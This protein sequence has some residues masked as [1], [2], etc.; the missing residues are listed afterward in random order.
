MIARRAAH[1]D[2]IISCTVRLADPII[3]SLQEEHFVCFNHSFM[4]PLSTISQALYMHLF[5]HFSNL[6][7]VQSGKRGLQFQKRYDD[8]CNEW[9]GGLTVKDRISHIK[10]DQLGR[11][12]GQLVDGKFLSSYAIEAAKSRE[13]FV[14]TFRPGEGFFSDYDQFYRHRNQG[15]LQWRFQ[16]DQRQVAEP[17]KV[18]YLF[19]EKKAGR[20]IAGI[21]YVS[22]AEMQ[23]AKDILARIAFADVGSFLDYALE[24][25]RTTNF[26]PQSLAGIVRYLEPFLASQERRSAAKAVHAAKEGQEAQRRAYDAFCRGL[27]SEV[28]A[29]LP[30]DEAAE[31]ERLATQSSARFSGNARMLETV[32][33]RVTMTR[34]PESVPSFD[35]WRLSQ[36]A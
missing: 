30:P 26:D 33:M 16:A 22:S 6:F 4:Q 10:R 5:F 11:H 20:P 21:P 8:I 7:E 28:L 35:Q 36:A 14:I 13:G 15:E 31:I 29:A 32:R 1:A 23:K 24:H 18:A 12:L 17:M 3:K 34:H 27:M 25:A 9:L 19:M 2:P